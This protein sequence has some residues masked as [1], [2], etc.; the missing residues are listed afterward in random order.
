MAFRVLK[1][2]GSLLTD[3]QVVEHLTLWLGRQPPSHD[4]MI[5]GGGSLVNELR[6]M[7]QRFGLGEEVSHQLALQLMSVTAR[8]MATLLNWPLV[9]SLAECTQFPCILEV[10]EFT[11]ESKLP[12]TWSV[13]S[14]SIAARLA[15]ELDAELVLLKST[16]DFDR[17]D[18][19]DE[20]FPQLQPALRS[21]RLANLR[22]GWDL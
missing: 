2:G 15:I 21:F 9:R 11:A 6:E 14:D 13:S 3:P 17:D 7:D 22:D 12:H 19:V 4:V 10:T 8:L 20:H 5:V 18:L 1:L 16:V